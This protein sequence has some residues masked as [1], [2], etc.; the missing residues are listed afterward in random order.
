[1]LKGFG[2]Y[3]ARHTFYIGEDGVIRFIDTKVRPR[4]AGPD[5]AS[6]LDAL[7]VRQSSA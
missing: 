3:T 7:G 1:M 6:R 4:T 5:V 2:L